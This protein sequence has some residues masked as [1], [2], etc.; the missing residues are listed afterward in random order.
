LNS[1][2]GK[3]ILVV[4]EKKI[5]KEAGEISRLLRMGLKRRLTVRPLRAH[6][7]AGATETG[8]AGRRGGCDGFDY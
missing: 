4:E 3:G 5:V 6:E 1:R 8:R 2:V 7:K